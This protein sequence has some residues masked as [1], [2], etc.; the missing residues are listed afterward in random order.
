LVA[1]VLAGIG[2]TAA[3]Q[4][5]TSTGKAQALLLE[6][7]RMLRLAKQQFEDL[8]A[9][10]QTTSMGGNFSDMGE[11]RYVWDAEFVPTGEEN[12]AELRVTVRSTDSVRPREET[13]TGLVF[14]LPQTTE[15]VQP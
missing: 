6:K 15:A 11:D 8:V 1:V 2:I 10:G 13:I 4:G 9:T 14:L 7:E 12:L 5:I 3:V